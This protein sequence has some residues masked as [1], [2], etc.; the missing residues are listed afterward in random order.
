MEPPKRKCSLGW[1]ERCE[2]SENKCALGELS[3]HIQQLVKRM[4]AG[5][6]EEKQTMLNAAATAACTAISNTKLS[7]HSIDAPSEKSTC[8]LLPFDDVTTEKCLQSKG[9]K[10]SSSVPNIKP[11]PAQV[12]SSEEPFGD[13]SLADLTESL[14]KEFT[15]PICQELFYNPSTL[16]CGHSFCEG[17][18]HSWLPKSHTCPLCRTAVQFPPSRAIGLDKAVNELAQTKGR[19]YCLQRQQ[20]HNE[21]LVVEDQKKVDLEDKLGIAAEKGAR[22]V[23]IGRPWSPREQYRFFRGLVLYKQGAVR[24]VYCGSIGL[25]EAF[26]HRASQLELAVAAANLNIKDQEELSILNLRNRLLMFIKFS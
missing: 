5:C 14:S 19:T 20:S 6:N 25:S 9:I 23:H 3:S 11:T 18:I 13:T 16:N 7:A 22:F 12:L 17:C 21:L 8:G 1:L 4:C 15:C 10:P 2:S 26:I 24:V